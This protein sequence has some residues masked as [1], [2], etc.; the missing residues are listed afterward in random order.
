M[1]YNGSCDA[2]MSSIFLTLLIP[3]SL[4]RQTN[5]GIF[6]HVCHCVD[7]MIFDVR[8]DDL[9]HPCRRS[10]PAIVF[11]FLLV[12][13]IRI[14][15]TWQTFSHTI[16]SV[17]KRGAVVDVVVAAALLHYDFGFALFCCFLCDYRF[18]FERALDD[19]C[20]IHICCENNFQSVCTFSTTREINRGGKGKGGNNLG[21]ME[22]KGSVMDQI[23]NSKEENSPK[24]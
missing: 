1:C 5:L 20:S 16:D 23:L 22:C 3:V 9:R 18:P 7:G 4:R 10:Q 14:P 13:F 19:I 17:L 24:L 11:I 8:I 12:V 15:V 21:V 2:Q 6:S